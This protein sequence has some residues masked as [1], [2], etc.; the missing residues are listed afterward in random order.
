MLYLVVVVGD[1]D[2]DHLES[3]HPLQRMIGKLCS[4]Q[5]LK[6]ENTKKIKK[7]ETL[8]ILLFIYID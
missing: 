5:N 1:H 7:K 2:Y 4:D 8:K 3:H 6:S